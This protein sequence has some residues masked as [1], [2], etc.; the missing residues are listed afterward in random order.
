MSAINPKQTSEEWRQATPPG[1]R[2][3]ANEYDQVAK[4]A[5]EAFRAKLPESQR[6][7]SHVPFAIY[8]NFLHA[9]ELALKSYMVHTGS[10]LGEL[11]RV[12]H[13]L[14][15]ALDLYIEKGIR[16]NCPKLTDLLVGTI[17][18]ASPTYKD[19]DFEYIRVGPI[20]L[21]HIDQIAM[22]SSALLAGIGN[23]EMQPA[24]PE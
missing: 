10:D 23:I 7:H 14:E 11:R 12:G 20:Q 16:D 3:Y 21:E 8:Y 2:R 4:D 17:R 13:N 5:L 22:A 15:E 19:K 9:I 18:H 24:N 1:L 6:H